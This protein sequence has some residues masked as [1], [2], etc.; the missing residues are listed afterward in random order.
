MQEFSIEK[1]KMVNKLKDF[2]SSKEEIILAYIYGSF[3]TDEWH[4]HSDIDIGVYVSKE[5]SNDRWY[6][7]ELKNA[8]DTLFEE[9]DRFDCKILNRRSPKFLYEVIHDTHLLIMKDFNTKID[10]E[11]SVFMG[12]YD[13]RHTWEEFYQTKKEMMAHHD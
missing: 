13:I 9:E 11:T 2:L 3:I 10:F 6:A 1:Q 5:K 4:A 12:W 8:L 7:I